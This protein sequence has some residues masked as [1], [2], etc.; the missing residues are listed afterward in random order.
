MFPPFRLC[1]STVWSEKCGP[2]TYVL[3]GK[4][5]NSVQ[6]ASRVITFSAREC[7]RTTFFLS[8]VFVCVCAGRVPRGPRCDPLDRDAPWKRQ[9]RLPFQPGRQSPAA[10]IL[11]RLG[12]PLPLR[13]LLH[14]RGR[15]Q[16]GLAHCAQEAWRAKGSGIG[17]CGQAPE[18]TPRGSLFGLRAAGALLSGPKAAGLWSGR[19]G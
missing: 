19:E 7:V 4:G 3:R 8:C 6:K 9:Q 15:A 5:D 14:G 12:L 1:S 13:L 2:P 18:R 16:S 11:P 17:D 10:G